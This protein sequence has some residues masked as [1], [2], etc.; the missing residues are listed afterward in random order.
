[1]MPSRVNPT[2]GNFFQQTLIRKTLLKRNII[3]AIDQN[4]SSQTIDDYSRFN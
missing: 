4:D 2:D 3:H 1:M